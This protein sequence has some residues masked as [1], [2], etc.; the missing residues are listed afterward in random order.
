MKTAQQI[1]AILAFSISFFFVT[2]A[3][4][5]YTFTD[6]WVNWPG[7]T[8]TTPTNIRDR[9]EWGTPQLDHID[10]NIVDGLL[11]TIDVVLH[12]S[13]TR[14][15]FDSL[16]INTSWDGDESL[17]GTWDNWTHFVHDGGANNTSHTAGVVPIVN[18]LY[19]VD[20]D[21]IYTTVTTRNRVSNPNGIDNGDLTMFD[22][23]IFG[24]QNGHHIT[25]DF[26][27]GLAITDGF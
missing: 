14:Q 24:D 25:Y 13:T 17:G 22:N 10:V 12:E 27:D 11:T 18:G 9:D 23:T 21:F 8:A 7:Y 26:G 4:A 5:T 3:S 19:T 6:S 20:A 15:A 2:S 16:F 1:S